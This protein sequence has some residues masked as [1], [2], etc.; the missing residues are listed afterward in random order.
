MT[1]EREPSAICNLSFDYVRLA[2]C[3][4]ARVLSRCRHSKLRTTVCDRVTSHRLTPAHDGRRQDSVHSI[5]SSTSEKLVS[6]DLDISKK[7][8]ELCFISYRKLKTVCRLLCC[9]L[10][11]GSTRRRFALCNFSSSSPLSDRSS[12]TTSQL[13]TSTLPHNSKLKHIIVSLLAQKNQEQEWRKAT[14]AKKQFLR[15]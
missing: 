2:C 10:Y 12:K 11:Y 7:S 9:R 1:W 5:Q 15:L 3:S 4:K 14:W 6:S 8:L 13:T